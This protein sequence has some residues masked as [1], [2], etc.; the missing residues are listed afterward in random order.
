MS[1]DEKFAAIRKG[2]LE[3]L[4]LKI[5]A[6]DKVYAADILAR[7]SETEFATQEG[8]LYPLLS[9]MR[10]DGLLDYEWRESD[11]GP[12]RKYYELTAKGTSQLDE[13]NAYWKQLN[14][15]VTKLGR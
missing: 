1:I 4:I 10:R 14:T 13:L 15:T 9:K 11:A 12:P 6:A 2:L 5:V 3:F 7:L 8:T